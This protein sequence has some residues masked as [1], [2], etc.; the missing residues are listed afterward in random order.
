MTCIPEVIIFFFF[1]YPSWLQHILVG[2]NGER[3]LSFT[4]YP[5]LVCSEHQW[6]Q[7]GWFSAPLFWNH[8]T[9]RDAA[10]LRTTLGR[11]SFAQN[12]I[13]RVMCM[14]K[15]YCCYQAAYHDNFLCHTSLHVHEFLTKHNMAMSL[16]PLYSP[17]LA[18]ANFSPPLKDE[19]PT[20]GIPFW[21]IEALQVTMT[22]ALN[23]V[24]VRAF[25]G[26][27]CAWESQWKKCM[28]VHGEHFQY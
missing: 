1:P 18:L 14:W 15:R 4:L 11:S 26:A 10:Y 13:K 2:L 22:T 27:Y 17:D 3:T 23:K 6:H 28:E 21:W 25:E 5:K 20:Q 24:P 9:M 7:D 16:Q 12:S 19:D 8:I